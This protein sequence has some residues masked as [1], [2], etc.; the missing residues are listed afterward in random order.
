MNLAQRFTV[1]ILGTTVL[2]GPLMAV[3]QGKAAITGLKAGL[4]VYLVFCFVVVLSC[5]VVDGD[6]TNARQVFEV[7]R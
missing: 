4:I 5:W 6:L 3:A 2:G 7:D 1:G